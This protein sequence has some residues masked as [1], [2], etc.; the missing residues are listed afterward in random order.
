MKL[1][2][3]SGQL[4]IV[5]LIAGCGKAVTKND[6]VMSAIREYFGKS[7]IDT[8]NN[9]DNSFRLYKQKTTN[10]SGHVKYLIIDIKN[11]QIV[12]QGAYAPGYIKW[13]S[14]DELELL[15]MPEVIKKEQTPADFKQILSVRKTFD[16]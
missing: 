16:Q 5:M 14:V 6:N 1:F 8:E 15:S 9:S 10:T 2:I 4:F 11:N 12:K 13:I 3:I 7:E